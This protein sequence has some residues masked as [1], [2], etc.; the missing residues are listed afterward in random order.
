MNRATL[1]RSVQEVAEHVSARVQGDGE[2]T[3]SGVS[4][5]ASASAG[6]L[7]FVEDEKNLRLALES[8]AAAVIAGDFASGTAAA[9]PLLISSQPRLAFAG[10]RSFFPRRQ[11][12]SLEFIPARQCTRRHV[13]RRRRPWKRERSSAKAW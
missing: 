11:N 4:S 2:I 10:P 6:A 12:M 8:P 7:V 5:I 9:K 13:W 3:V 1:K